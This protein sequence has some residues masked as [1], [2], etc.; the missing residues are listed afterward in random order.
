MRRKMNQ[1]LTYL[2]ENF[3]GLILS[4]TGT[5]T[6]YVPEIATQQIQTDRFFQHTV[7][8]LTIIVAILTIVGWVQNQIKRRKEK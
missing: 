7:W 8:T 5:V 2:T 1:L 4:I 3:R 6:G